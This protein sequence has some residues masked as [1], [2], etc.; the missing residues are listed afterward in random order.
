MDADERNTPI[1]QSAHPL[2]IASLTNSFSGYREAVHFPEN[3]R[4]RKLS[5]NQQLSS[6]DFFRSDTL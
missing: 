2:V 3:Q 4:K 5:K 6:A 1:F